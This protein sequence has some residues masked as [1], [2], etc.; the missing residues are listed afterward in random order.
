ML[1][2][3][4]VTHNYG[5]VKAIQNISL[6]FYSDEITLVVGKNGSGKS[7]LLRLLSSQEYPSQGRV[8]ADLGSV[9][10]CPQ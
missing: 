2:L 7:T 3:K 5:K 9:G 6:S 8:E 1:E 10:Y 4:G